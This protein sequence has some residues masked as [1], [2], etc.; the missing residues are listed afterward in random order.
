MMN[1]PD[2]EAVFVEALQNIAEGVTDLVGFE[3]AAISIARDDHTLEM[4]AVAGSQDARDQLLGHHTPIEE[5][6]RELVTAEEW[7]DLRFVPHERMSIEVEELGWVPDI[8]ASDDPDAWH[9]LDLLLAPIHDEH[10][11]LRGLLSVDLPRD[12]RR[13]GPA[14]RELLQRYA[15]QTRRSV[16]T[17]LERAEFAEQVRMADAARRIVR[18]VSSELSIGRIV[19]ICQPA[20]TTGFNAVGMWLQTYDADGRGTDEVYGATEGD[21][22]VPDEFK[23]AG[24]EAA[25]LLWAQQEVTV[26]DLES[27]PVVA[28]MLQDPAQV[29]RLHDFM[30]KTLEASSMLFVPIGAGSECLGNLAL[31]RRGD[32]TDWSPVEQQAALEIGHDLGRALVNARTFERERQ[33]LQELRDLAGYKSRLIATIS[34]EL[35]NPLASIVGHLELIDLEPDLTMPMT[36]STAAIGRAAQ[37]MSSI[38]DDL[39]LLAQ[40]ADPDTVLEPEPVDLAAVVDDVLDLLH[41]TS[42]QKNLCVVLDVPPPPT[43]VL[44]AARELYQVCV[45]LISNAVK[46]TPAGGTIA[47]TLACTPTDVQL[48]VADTGIGISSTDQ[49]RLFQEFFRSTNPAALAT[50]GTGLGLS[51]V[52]RIVER[53]HGR[54]ALESDLGTGTTVTVTLPPAP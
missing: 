28:G 29:Q 39:L 33:L 41:V 49:D 48:V 2:I 43:Y 54:I 18:Q 5:I 53:H 31:T 37:R 14:Q 30:A 27:V 32:R 15:R 52:Q 6:E 17:A 4:V 20:I 44:G 13:P 50:P 1:Q 35:K 34:H 12:R 36:Q 23:V 19:E 46:Y 16:L 45:N 7:G 42:D 38:I 21:I 47:V 9:P 24:R 51:I 10:N 26:V 40:V 22:A 25:H 3:V 8:E 11:R